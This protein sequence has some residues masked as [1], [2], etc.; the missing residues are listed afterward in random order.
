MRLHIAR[1]VHQSTLRT[2]TQVRAHNTR[3]MSGVHQR[4][5]ADM[6]KFKFALF[7][8]LKRDDN[9]TDDDNSTDDNTTS[10]AWSD[11]SDT[12]TTLNNLVP[13]AVSTLKDAKTEI[14]EV[15]SYLDN[16]FELF[17]I[18]GPATFNMVAEINTIIWTIYYILLAPIAL[19]MLYY[20]FWAGGYFGGPQPLPKDEDDSERPKT[21]REKCGACWSCCCSCCMRCHDTQ[22]CFWSFVVI[23]QIIVLV[24]FLISII[25][26]IL[27]IIKAFLVVS[28]DQIYL[29]SDESTCYKYLS[30]MQ[31]FVSTFYVLDPNENLTD[32]CNAAN[33]M[34]C[35]LI[36]S[37]LSSSAILT[38]VF[39]FLGCVVTMQMIIESA[40]LHEQ[41][42]YP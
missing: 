7:K 39:S 40:V 28:C 14:S 25:L 21:W 42:R 41:A 27:A 8:K 19:I 22:I 10:T 34:A 6:D 33:L 37:N 18:T 12:L 35:D 23:M 26:C 29:L 31:T 9:T 16:L 11:L 20:A 15:A 17:E 5:Q 1:N 38:C 32:V 24:M 36:S 30:L 3:V 2:L 13:T 4:F